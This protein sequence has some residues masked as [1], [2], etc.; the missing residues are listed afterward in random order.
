[1]I[2]IMDYSLSQQESQQHLSP[3]LFLGAKEALFCLKR[4]DTSKG[5][6]YLMLTAPY[7]GAWDCVRV[8]DKILV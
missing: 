7:P 4:G 6:S 2:P 1:M 8:C 3:V 5:G